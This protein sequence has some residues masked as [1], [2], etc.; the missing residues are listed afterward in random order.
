LLLDLFIRVLPFLLQMK[1]VSSLDT[2][3]QAWTFKE[4]FVELWKFL[5]A[6]HLFDYN[7]ILLHYTYMSMSGKVAGYFL[8]LLTNL[9]DYLLPQFGF[10]TLIVTITDKFSFRGILWTTYW[11]FE[12]YLFSYAEIFWL[13]FR[14]WEHHHFFFTS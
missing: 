4:Q 13:C 6:S 3:K 5:W 14:F 12:R 9:D 8:I 2:H 10:L 1:L 7:V 11:G